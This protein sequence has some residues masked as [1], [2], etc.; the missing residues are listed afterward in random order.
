MFGLGKKKV[1]GELIAERKLGV[2]H[3]GKV[4]ELTLRV[5]SPEPKSERGVNDGWIC[6]LEIEGLGLK[7]NPAQGVSSFDALIHALAGMRQILREEAKMGKR[8]YFELGTGEEER[9]F[10]STEDIFWSPGK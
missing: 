9:D 6:R 5:F 1:P 4:G 3:H 8:R 7:L 2:I 10:L